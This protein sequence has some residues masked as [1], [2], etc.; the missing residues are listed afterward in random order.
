MQTLLA[1]DTSVVAAFAEHRTALGVGI[2]YAATALG[3]TA[4]ILALSAVLA[5]YFALRHRRLVIPLALDI[6][7]AFAAFEILKDLVAR[8]R[9][10]AALALY[11]PPL[12]SFPSGHATMAAAFYGFSAFA[13]ARAWPRQRGFIWL[14][15]LLLIALIGVSRVYLG[16]HYP[17][18]VIAGWLL[19]GFFAWLGAHLAKRRHA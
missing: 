7:G 8:P 12:Y 19:G 13:L 6:L 15:A 18:D 1:L 3:S 17:S 2:A 9:P 16:V 5:L 14:A 4:T 11:T 10:P